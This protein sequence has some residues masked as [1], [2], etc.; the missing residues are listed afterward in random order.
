MGRPPGS[1]RAAHRRASVLLKAQ[2]AM[3][4]ASPVRFTSV[5]VGFSERDVMNKI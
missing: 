5:I 4:A 1:R 3:T 2:V